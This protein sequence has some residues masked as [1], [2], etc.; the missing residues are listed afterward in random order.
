MLDET[1]KINNQLGDSRPI[2]LDRWMATLKDDETRLTPFKLR[3]FK[4]RSTGSV[5]S[6]QNPPKDVVAA[7]TPDP[8]RGSDKLNVQ[9][10]NRV[11]EKL[12]D[13]LDHDRLD[14]SFMTL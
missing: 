3:W 1:Q 13:D 7:V 12:Q 4:I 9:D 14:V 8:D 11:T 6:R 2:I 10:L 5:N